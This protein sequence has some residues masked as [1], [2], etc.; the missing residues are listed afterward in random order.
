MAIDERAL[1][2]AWEV[3][4]RAY[5]EAEDLQEAGAT[6]NPLHWAFQKAIEAYLAALPNYEGGLAEIVTTEVLRAFNNGADNLKIF[7]TV[8]A[9]L[10]AHAAAL[11]K[12]QVREALVAHNDLLRSAFQAAQRDAIQDTDGTT[13]YRLL[14]DRASEVL[15][16]YHTVTNEARAALSAPCVTGCGMSYAARD[17]L[18]ERQRQ[19]EIEGWTLEHDDTHSNGEMARAGAAYAYHA[20]LSGE[21]RAARFPQGWPV[22]WALSWWKPTDRRR[23]LVKAGALIIAEIERLDRLPSVPA[24]GGDDGE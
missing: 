15:G 14:A 17:V 24:P 19:I 16:K 7:E 9:A 8:K 4:N 21:R 2:A 23:D 18:A 10:A 20:G 6:I 5:Y 12:C 22:G 13:N 1:E 3:G 11:P